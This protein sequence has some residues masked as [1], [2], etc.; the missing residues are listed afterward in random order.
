MSPISISTPG[1]DMYGGHDPDN[2]WEWIVMAIVLAAGMVM[3]VSLIGCYKLCCRTGKYLKPPSGEG[4]I[5]YKVKDDVIFVSVK[6]VSFLKNK[7]SSE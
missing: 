1:S 2:H 7:T 4:E 5:R 3:G 6:N